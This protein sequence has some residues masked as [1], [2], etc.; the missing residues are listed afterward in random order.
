MFED[1]KNQMN[2][3]APSVP[4]LP[5]SGVNPQASPM[6]SANQPTANQLANL[7]AA[8]RPKH[9]S[10]GKLVAILIIFI[11]V[12][13][14]AGLGYWYWQ[15]NQDQIKAVLL[16]L[17]G[18]KTGE[19]NIDFTDPFASSTQELDVTTST[20]ELDYGWTKSM[21]ELLSDYN[22]VENWPSLFVCYLSKSRI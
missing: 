3:Q 15:N 16:P 12:L 20:D 19:I 13:G 6:L 8:T 22:Q 14:V 7:S 18:I 4:P 5:P 17:A 1:V 2:S 21:Q 11:L 10:R 9:S